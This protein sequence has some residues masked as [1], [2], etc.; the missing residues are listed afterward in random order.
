M[1]M[2]SIIA[3][4]IA[5]AYARSTIVW[6][7]AGYIFGWPAALLVFFLGVKP[8]RWEQR[9]KYFE[10]LS[11]KAEEFANNLQEQHKPKGYKDFNNVDDLFKQLENNK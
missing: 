5:F 11:F 10:E 9:I 6:A 7:L 4:L 3:G 2:W 1:I 8:K